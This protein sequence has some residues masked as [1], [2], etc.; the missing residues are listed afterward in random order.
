M[1]N[2]LYRFDTAIEFFDFHRFSL[3]FVK[4]T[5]LLLISIDTDF[6]QLTTLGIKEIVDFIHNNY[7]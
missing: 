3:S 2:Q 6:Y 7:N 5:R 4:I 1:K